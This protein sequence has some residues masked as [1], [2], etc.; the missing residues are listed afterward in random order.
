MKLEDF[1]PYQLSVLSNKISHGIAKFYREQHGIS[2]AQWRVLALL[3]DKTNQTAKELCERSQMDKVRVSRTVKQLESKNYI[4]EKP[5]SKDARARRYRL[6]NNG[7]N[8]INEVKPK[9][10][11][12]EKELISAFSNVELSQLK[13]SISKLNTTTDKITSQIK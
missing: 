2:V 6:T 8:L 11:E 5:C 7:K 1:L 3:S 13:L 4:L 10:L 12:F 9:A